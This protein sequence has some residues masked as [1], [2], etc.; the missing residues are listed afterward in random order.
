M[1]SANSKGEVKI[2]SR[3]ESINLS[4]FSANE[5]RIR[6]HTF[7]ASFQMQLD[8][9]SLECKQGSFF[10]STGFIK[11]SFWRKQEPMISRKCHVLHLNNARK[12]WALFR[13]LLIIYPPFSASLVSA[14]QLLCF[15]INPWCSSHPASE[16]ADNG[17]DNSSRG[18]CYCSFRLRWVF[19]SFLVY[20]LLPSL[21]L[22]LF[23][24]LSQNL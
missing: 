6:M 13:N 8:V 5:I 4:F 24:F 18:K 7:I 15:F 12:L 21:S 16:R 20:F 19:S 9:L 23:V 10:K 1:N 17:P 2:A 3:K 14:E 11:M 22:T